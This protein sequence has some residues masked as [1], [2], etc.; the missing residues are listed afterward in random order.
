MTDDEIARLR[1]F[2]AELDQNDDALPRM[3]RRV[4]E[5]IER[6]SAPA[7]P[8]RRWIVAAAGAAASV[9]AIV[10]VSAVMSNAADPDR[11]G[12]RPGAPPSVAAASAADPLATAPAAEAWPTDLTAVVERLVGLSAGVQPVEVPAGKA[13]H[14]ASRGQQRG[15]SPFTQKIWYE[16][17]GQ[18]LLRS[19]RT[20]PGWMNHTTSAGERDEARAELAREGP[21]FGQ[22]TRAYLAG[23]PTTP[24]HLLALVRPA[25]RSKEGAPTGDHYLF[26]SYVELF[27][28]MQ[29]VLTPQLRAAL[30]RTLPLVNGVRVFGSTNVGGRDVV[31]IVHDEPGRDATAMLFD[32]A[33]GEVIG[34]ASM[35]ADG[36]TYVSLWD[37]RTVVDPPPPGPEATPGKKPSPGTPRGGGPSP[38]GASPGGASPNG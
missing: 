25:P 12:Q 1:R 36:F 15:D 18:I 13:L 26:K 22:S 7:S 31:V 33:T 16:P 35:G 23:L 10:T 8:R 30:Y 28:Y 38:G 32:P 24:A 9:V 14:L 5:G 21:N 2:R 3:R 4:T 37:A 17:D 20:G 34:D 11:A 19:V 6:P 27:M 29:P